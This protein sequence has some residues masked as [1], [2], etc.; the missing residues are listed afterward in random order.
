LLRLYSIQGEMCDELTR[1]HTKRAQGKTNHS[2][3]GE[4]MK[5]KE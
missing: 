2:G 3:S 5:S 4:E 1:E